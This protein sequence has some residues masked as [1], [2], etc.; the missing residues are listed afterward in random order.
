M[1]STVAA[2]AAHD[3]AREVRVRSVV[4]TVVLM[5]CLA[6]ASPVLA[7]SPWRVAVQE[8]SPRIL[9]TTADGALALGYDTEGR[10]V[11]H[12]VDTRVGRILL[13]LIFRDRLVG[14]GF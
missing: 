14:A 8:G 2:E 7:E 6:P 13:T 1:I 10:H 9:A 11:L 4:R 5:I 3:R 12:A